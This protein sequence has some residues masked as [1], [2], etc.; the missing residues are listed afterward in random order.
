MKYYS[1]ILIN[2]KKGKFIVHLF[3]L[4]KF[5][6]TV[7]ILTTKLQEKT[8]T[9]GNSTTIIK[10]VIKSLEDSRTT[11]CFKKIWS[12]IITFTAD[13]NISNENPFQ[14]TA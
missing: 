8:A 6:T 2:I 9:L 7:N 13:N 12:D 10:A 14:G 3:L 1:G 4:H 5:L 11:E